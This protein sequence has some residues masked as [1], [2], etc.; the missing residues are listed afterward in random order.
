MR[1][2]G[3]VKARALVVVLVACVGVLGACSGERET[4]GRMRAFDDTGFPP[5]AIEDGWIVAL[6]AGEQ[7]SW[8]IVGTV[9]SAELGNDW[10]PVVEADVLAAGGVW[11]PL[12]AGGRFDLPVEPGEWLLCYVPYRDEGGVNGII[13]GCGVVELEKGSRIDASRGEGG[14]GAAV[15]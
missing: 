6:P 12:G 10:G 4:G 5:D 9:R 8:E 13:N 3:R 14:F 2:T 7:D 11:Q 1:V 15:D